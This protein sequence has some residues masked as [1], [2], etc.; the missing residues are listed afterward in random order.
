MKFEPDRAQEGFVNFGL[1]ETKSN[2]SVS[3]EAA[4]IWWMLAGPF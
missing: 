3:N 4:S 2:R 1:C